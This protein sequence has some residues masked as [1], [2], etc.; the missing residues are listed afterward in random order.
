MA[1]NIK[2]R[3]EDTEL[4]GCDELL[5]STSSM[6]GT[7]DIIVRTNGASFCPHGVYSEKLIKSTAQI[8]VSHS[9][10][11]CDKGEASMCGED[12]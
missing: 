6:L 4:L 12:V 5:L 2:I 9:S 10:N 8:H 7:Q 3:N 1:I 11:G